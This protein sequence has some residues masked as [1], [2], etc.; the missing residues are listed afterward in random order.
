MEASA[1]ELLVTRLLD[2]VRESGVTFIEA[3]CALKAAES[4]VP[5]IGLPSYVR[6][7]SEQSDVEDQ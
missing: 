7:L 4:L 1:S 2:V 5:S 3:Q 6:T